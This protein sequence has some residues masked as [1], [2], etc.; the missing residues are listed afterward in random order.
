ML[1]HATRY[2]SAASLLWVANAMQ[3]AARRASAA[4]K[5]LDAWL[6]R[7]RLASVA[8][9]E[10]GTMG[11]RELHDIGI[12]RADVNR[13][14]WGASTRDWERR[15]PESDRKPDRPR[16]PD[17]GP[18]GNADRA[19]ALSALWL[20]IGYIGTAALVIGLLQAF[21][22]GATILQTLILILFGAGLAI[23]GWRRARTALEPTGA[24][25]VAGA[26]AAA[27]DRYPRERARTVERR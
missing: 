2:R 16:W 23:A 25:P 26:A 10:L 3:F 7:R 22:G 24:Q 11:E 8:L 15:D 12:D 1:M 9:R 20:D 18:P 13:V 6:E 21:G 5:R 4:A 17:D 14:A 19:L 27:A